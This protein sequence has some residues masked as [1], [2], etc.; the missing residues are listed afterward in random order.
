ML[1]RETACSLVPARNGT[2]PM[3]SKREPTLALSFRAIM[4]SLIAESWSPRGERAQALIKMFVKPLDCLSSWRSLSSHH[5]PHS[6][7]F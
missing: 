2:D 5:R 7:R 1:S 3:I 6:R 4:P